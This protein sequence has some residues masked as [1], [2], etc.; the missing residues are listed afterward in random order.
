[1]IACRAALSWAAAALLVAP[2]LGLLQEGAPHR[3]QNRKQSPVVELAASDAPANYGLRLCNAFAWPAPLEMSRIEEPKLVEYPLPYKQCH[4]YQLPLRN[5][6][7]LKF[8]A[9][10]LIIGTFAVTG[11]PSKTHAKD[12]VLL[13][14]PY[15][16]DTKSNV[17]AFSS[18]IYERGNDAQVAVVD[19]YKGPDQGQLFLRERSSETQLKFNTVLTLKPQQ[20]D[21]AVR[22]GNQSRA[23]AHIHPEK[24]ELYTVVHIGLGTSKD[25]WPEELLVFPQKSFGARATASALV[26]LLL[27]AWTPSC[28]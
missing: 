4:D 21:F 13:L 25:P 17:V 8:R 6:D 12:V 28:M 26:L 19:T 24:E 3:R 16:L 27:S 14:V 20:Y 5:G 15:R 1:M 22:H 9:G 7:S 2:G 18:H 10:E 23:E 11:L